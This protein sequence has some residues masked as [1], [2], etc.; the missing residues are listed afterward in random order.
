MQSIIVML[1]AGISP[2]M[3]A[4]NQ[5]AKSDFAVLKTGSV[6]FKPYT[7][8]DFNNDPKKTVSDLITLPNNKQVKLSDYLNAINTVEKNLA[9]IGFDAR[10]IK[11]PTVIAAYKAKSPTLQPQIPVNNLQVLP[12]STLQQRFTAT[13]LITNSNLITKASLV[14]AIAKTQQVVNRSQTPDPF[15]F[16]VGDYKVKLTPSF[17][18]TGK[19][20]P[21]DFT[22]DAQRNRDTLTAMVK[23]KNNQYSLG[24]NVDITTNIPVLGNVSVYKLQ[25]DFQA[26]SSK[27]SAM[28]SNV[29]LKV[30]EQVLISE[31]KS[32]I[33]TDT[34]SFT[35]QRDYNL[36]KLIGSADVFMYGLNLLSPVNFY[37]TGKVGG[38]F[39]V[40]LSRTGITGQIGPTIA[41]SI[42]LESSVLDAVGAG[43]IQNNVLDAGVGGE[44]KLIQG[45]LN[46][47]G[48]TGITAVNNKIKLLNDVYNSFS[49]EFLKGRLYTYV[50]YPVYL[51]NSI[52]SAGD[53]NCWGIRRVE[54]NLFATN[55]ALQF[56][57]SLIDDNQNTDLGW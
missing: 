30:L 33:H 8:N 27:D 2:A 29:M 42:I 56:N 38:S 14:K 16:T 55:A 25:S 19:T 17:T 3:Y 28:K 5:I 23:N 50:S 44:L 21:L 43:I 49:L 18:M 48:S 51:C 52:F 35:Q 11:T 26:R 9:D 13:S 10:Q 36:N 40:D 4:Q 57:F 12:A 37:L 32:N 24:M 34:Y 7:I 22:S 20:D 46:F 1:A 39:D 47:G 31:N 53:P 41:Q 6:A 15:S 54:N 45:T